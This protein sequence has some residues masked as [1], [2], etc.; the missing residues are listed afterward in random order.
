M[1]LDS[2]EM[3][4]IFDQTIIV[5]G[6][7]YGIVKGYHELPYV[8]IG[9]ATETGF[10]T[11]RVKGKVM[12]SPRFVIAPQHYGPRYEDLFGAE[13]ID[14][15]LVGRMFGFIGFRDKPVECKSEYVNVDH[16]D[17]TV[18]Q[19][20]SDTLDELERREDITSGVLIC[21]NAQYYPISVEKFISSILDDEFNL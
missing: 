7:R 2:R 11:T 17:R 19:V 14:K 15:E 16:M 1:S 5:R 20:L 6:P 9:G 4:A 12:V 10:H 18:D 3:R 13:H 21:P 8:C